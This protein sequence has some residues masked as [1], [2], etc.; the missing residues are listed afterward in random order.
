MTADTKV[1]EIKKHEDGRKEMLYLMPLERAD[2]SEVIQTLK[3]IADESSEYL[4]RNSADRNISIEEEEAWINKMN[5]SPTNCVIAAGY[6]IRKGG[7][8]SAPK[9]IGNLSLRWSST[10]RLRHR[11]SIGIALLKEYTHKGFG[12]L[13]LKEA[14][15]FAK[16]NGI[17]VLELQVV[18]TN[19][20]A[21]N[22]YIKNGYKIVGT[23]N[24][25][26]KYEDGTY[27]DMY[28]LQ[29]IL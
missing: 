24:K 15:I 2:A 3:Q 27:A 12:T 8:Y 4:S 17:E 9:Y 7:L 28:T 29:K 18:Y 25:A 22:C 26:L 23:L 5:E 10:P 20:P 21:I 1:I 16:A 14:E 13:L 19:T 6:Q 11:A